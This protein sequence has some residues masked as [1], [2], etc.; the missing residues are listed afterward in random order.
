ML[1]REPASKNQRRALP[2]L[3]RQP[4][5]LL[6]TVL[7]A[8][9]WTACEA[10]RLAHQPSPLHA[11][12]RVE[13]VIDLVTVAFT[14]ALAGGLGWLLVAGLLRFAPALRPFFGALVPGLLLAAL[15]FAADDALGWARHTD[16]PT[17]AGGLLVACAWAVAWTASASLARSP[18]LA[19]A[20]GRGLDVVLA[21]SLV[22]LPVRALRA[23][24][25]RPHIVLIGIDGVNADRLSAYGAER[26]T[27]PFLLSLR[28]RALF[29]ENAFTNN[30]CTSGALVALWTSRLPIDLRVFY[31]PQG[32][33]ESDAFDHLPE[34]LRTLGYDNYHFGYSP[35]TN[36]WSLNLRN[37]FSESNGHGDDLSPGRLRARLQSV[38][39]GIEGALLE[40]LGR[41]IGSFGQDAREPLAKAQTTVRP[42]DLDISDKARLDR[43]IDVLREARGPVFVHVHLMNTH[44]P[45][46]PVDSMVFARGQSQTEWWMPDFRDDAIRIADESLRDFYQRMQQL[47]VRDHTVVV[48]YSDHGQ[49]WDTT[50]R[51]PLVFDFPGDRRGRSITENVQLIDVAPTLLDH[52]GVAPPGW[53]VG[54]SLLRR[55]PDPYRPVVAVGSVHSEYDGRS[56]WE[57]VQPVTPPFG[58]GSLTTVICDQWFRYDLDLDTTTSGRVSTHVGH[59]DPRRVPPAPTVFATMREQLRVTGIRPGPSTR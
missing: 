35:Y 33:S 19:R 20:L 16:R 31:P 39:L 43:A 15:A 38:G 36:A 21:L 6:L 4:P 14:V 23:P 17:L 41:R 56:H 9:L 54:R 2:S 13:L 53:M 24:R 40:S 12:G 30:C 22:A 7:G 3:G 26:S 44:G 28:S 34:I 59:C 46:F 52:L 1:H 57:I 10:I 37:G 55:S 29:A 18:R 11:A 51:V 58:V 50:A 47:G 42:Q 49:H 45:T 25:R 5:A 48:I 27:S 32:L 8:Y